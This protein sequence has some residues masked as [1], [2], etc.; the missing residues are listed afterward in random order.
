[1]NISRI[2]SLSNPLG[3]IKTL[4][5]GA[6]EDL[7]ISASQIKNFGALDQNPATGT[8]YLKLCYKP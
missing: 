3:A 2:S 6:N 8:V 4:T 1:M 7:S 5:A